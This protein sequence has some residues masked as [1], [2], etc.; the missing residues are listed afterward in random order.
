MEIGARGWTGVGGWAAVIAGP[1]PHLLP[2]APSAGF[3]GSLYPGARAGTSPSPVVF[4][5][6]SPP[7]GTTPP[8]GP[9]SRMFS[10]KAS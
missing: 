6:G 3:G 2:P 9:R 5:V 8:P 4:T 10:G 7:S 1:E